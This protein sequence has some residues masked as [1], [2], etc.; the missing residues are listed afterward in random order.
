MPLTRYSHIALKKIDY[1]IKTASKAEI[2][3][4]FI[5]VINFLLMI[6]AAIVFGF[7]AE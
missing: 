4:S 2:I 1:D 5:T 7:N 6:I 3:M